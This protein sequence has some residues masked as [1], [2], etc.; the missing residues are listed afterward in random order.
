MSQIINNEHCRALA[1]PYYH[2]IPHQLY[3]EAA[4]KRYTQEMPDVHLDIL[5]TARNRIPTEIFPKMAINMKNIIQETE[6]WR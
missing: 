1:T 5:K 2:Y 6:V 4:A 3:P